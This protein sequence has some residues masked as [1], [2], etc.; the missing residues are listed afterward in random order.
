MSELLSPSTQCLVQIDEIG[1]VHHV[2][3][4]FSQVREDTADGTRLAYKV[5][6][7]NGNIHVVDAD[8]VLAWPLI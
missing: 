4:V 7:I 5:T 3:T 2:M 8:K 1:V 6:D